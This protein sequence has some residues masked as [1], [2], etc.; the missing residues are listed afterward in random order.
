MELSPATSTSTC[1]ERAGTHSSVSYGQ[2]N[3]QH[4]PS[5]PPN[6]SRNN[7]NIGTCSAST[8]VNVMHVS[9]YR[10]FPIPQVAPYQQAAYYIPPYPV[11]VPPPYP[12][13]VPFVRYPLYNVP[14]P[15]PTAVRNTQYHWVKSTPV[16][17]AGVNSISTFPSST[18][19]ITFSQTQTVAIASTLHEP[20]SIAFP[21]E[22]VVS[23]AVTALNNSKTDTSIPAIQD[24]NTLTIAKKITGRI[25]SLEDL[26]VRSLYHLRNSVVTTSI[27]KLITAT[28]APSLRVAIFTTIASVSN[29]SKTITSVA[30]PS[31]RD[32]AAFS[33]QL[34][35][36]TIATSERISCF[37]QPVCSS[38]TVK[39]T[40]ELSSKIVTTTVVRESCTLTASLIG[41]RTSSTVVANGLEDAAD[42]PLVD[43]PPSLSVWSEKV[44]NDE[45]DNFCS[46]LIR[47]VTEQLE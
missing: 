35:T 38:D 25:P 12:V 40:S 31:S 39:V 18:V 30:E 2:T 19:P 8:S 7:F 36:G 13:Q 32:T 1:C 44:P 5:L 16:E 41:P 22:P 4:Q 33:N 45:L 20:I 3:P 27:D 9:P 10:I 37:N 11:Q 15:P 14:T 26:T 28:V 17:T 23:L 24:S 29:E 42:L 34:Q 6:V 43:L 21:N 46:S 47:Q